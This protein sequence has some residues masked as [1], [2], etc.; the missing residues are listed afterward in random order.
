MFW[1]QVEVDQFVLY[2][3]PA[4][5]IALASC[6]GPDQSA[7]SVHLDHVASRRLLLPGYVVTYSTWGV[8][9]RAIVNGHT[10]QVWGV[11]QEAASAR[12]LAKSASNF[13]VFFTNKT[14]E[15]TAASIPLLCKVSP[16]FMKTVVTWLVMPLLRAC[17]KVVFFPPVFIGAALSL[18]GLVAHATLQ[19]LRCSSFAVHSRNRLAFF[20]HTDILQP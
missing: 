5:D 15:I 17:A 11:Q 20:P 8:Q 6:A 4:F 10:G 14:V 2:E 3:T 12:L 7:G 16:A 19:P 9:L 1:A 13:F 18:S